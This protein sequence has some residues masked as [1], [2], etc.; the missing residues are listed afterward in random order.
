MDLQIGLSAEKE[1]IVTENDLASFAGNFGADVLSTHRIVLLMEQ[2]ARKIF[3]GRIPEGKI[4]LGTYINIRHFSAAPVGSRV[5][6]VARLNAINGNKL[7]FQVGA[8]DE[9]EKL[10]EGEN[11][12]VIVSQDFFI[13]KIKSKSKN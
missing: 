1:M 11:E 6:A 9:T 12:H 10:A 2:A 7:R 8:Y 13:K 3:D 4:G 5:R